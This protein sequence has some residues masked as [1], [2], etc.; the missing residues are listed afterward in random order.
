[1]PDDAAPD[2]CPPPAALLQMMTGYWVSQALYVAAK[3]GVADLLIDGPRSI[4]H[5]AVA[6]Q[7]HPA[8]L[9]R[10]LRA[11]ASVG[12]FH[13]NEPWR[14]RTDASGGAPADR[15]TRLNACARHHVRGRAVPRVGQRVAQRADGGDRVRPA[16]WPE[17]FRVPRPASRG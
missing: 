14:L 13:R 1:M 17:L 15:D 5:L 10:V 7:A 6:S 9:R 2:G 4:E 11:L 12:G 8:S 3:L 16:I